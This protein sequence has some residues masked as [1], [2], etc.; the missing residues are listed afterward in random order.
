[1]ADCHQNFCDFDG[2]I[3]LTDARIKKLKKSRNALRDRIRDDFKEKHKN[4]V[5]PKFWSQGSIEMGTAVNPI[6]RDVQDEGE[7][8]KLLKYDIDDGIYFIGKESDR[9]SVHTYHSWIY[10][11]V[12]GH[13]NTPPIDKNTCVRTI[14][15]DGHNI[16]QPIYF[17]IDE[18]G[19]V[20]QLA[21]KKLGWIDSDPREF[22]NWFN[23]KATAN[24]QLV[25]LVRY[26]K[27]WCDYQ[28]FK[29]DVKRMPMGLV[30]TIWVSENAAYNVRDDIAMRDT[31]VNIK[32]LVD[33][34]NKLSCERP[35]VPK[36]ENLLEDYKHS[37]FFRGRLSA[38]V[39]AATQA[40]NETNPKNGCGKWQ[41]HFGDRFACSTANDEDEESTA[42]SAPAIITSNA[43]SA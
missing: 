23:G 38:F 15:S 34:Q 18:N 42:F 16:D 17:E 31:L 7:T 1:M 28:N 32:T 36:G 20:P 10:N 39:E 35:T 37:D 13:T 2:C 5:K 40:I 30:M 19:K 22:K 41:T 4:E 27:A 26:L 6:P 9:K 11:A 21:H 3:V 12:D 29:A 24:S 8:V 33:G 25:R 43:K 14:F